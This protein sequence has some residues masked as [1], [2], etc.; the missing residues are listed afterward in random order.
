MTT[1]SKDPS[2]AE[3]LIDF[4]LKPSSQELLQ[5]AYTTVTAVPDLKDYPGTAQWKKWGQTHQHYVIQDQSLTT[6]QSNSYFSIQ[7]DVVQG[8]QTPAAAAAAMAKAVPVSN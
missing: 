8:K 3:A 1:Q 6:D 7:S 4:W 5:N 2:D